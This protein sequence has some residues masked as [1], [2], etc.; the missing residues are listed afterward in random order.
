MTWKGGCRDRHYYIINIVICAHADGDSHSTSGA[1][2]RSLLGLD[3]QPVD[4]AVECYFSTGLAS[5]TRKTYQADQ[6]HYLLFCVQLGIFPVPA[7]EDTCRFVAVLA[8]QGIAHSTIKVYLS[9]M[10][11][12]HIAKKL[13]DL[14][15][16][17]HGKIISGPERNLVYITW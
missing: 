3:L 14:G 13:P 12:L 11:Q 5:A 10:H 8:S 4:R 16:G 6:R 9:A 17:E 2:S 1:T 15:N 7:S